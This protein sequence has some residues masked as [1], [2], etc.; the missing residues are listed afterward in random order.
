VCSKGARLIVLD[1]ITEPGHQ[2]FGRVD[3]LE[4]PPFIGLTMVKPPD[5]TVDNLRPEIEQILYRAGSG[6]AGSRGPTEWA[7]GAIVARQ[8]TKLGDMMQR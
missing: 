3:V 8:D 4:F 6:G 5:V 7:H 1:R 2:R